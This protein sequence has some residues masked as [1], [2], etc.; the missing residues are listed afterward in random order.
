LQ[1]DALLASRMLGAMNRPGSAAAAEGARHEAEERAR[2]SGYV[3]DTP[4]T[5]ANRSDAE[6]LAHAV[7]LSQRP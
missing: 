7:W 6:A 5:R 3:G 4:W 1:W 2:L